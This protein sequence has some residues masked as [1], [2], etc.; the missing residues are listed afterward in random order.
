MI[1]ASA[2]AYMRGQTEHVQIAGAYAR[3]WALWQRHASLHATGGETTLSPR[4]GGGAFAAPRVRR[5]RRTQSRRRV[6]LSWRTECVP[7]ARTAI[8]VAYG[9]C[10]GRGQ[11]E[12]YA[13]GPG[14]ADE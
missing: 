4:K 6:H 9:D 3:G 10:F 11:G 12:E 2:F 14:Q 1:S 8:P 7:L 5:L 13:L